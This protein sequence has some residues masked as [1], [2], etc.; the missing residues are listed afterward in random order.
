MSGIELAQW[1][2]GKEPGFPVVFTSGYTS[3]ADS[4]ETESGPCTAFLSKPFQP[5]QLAAAIRQVLAGAADASYD[6]QPQP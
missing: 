4:I 2:R 3:H 6:T 5:S 1:F